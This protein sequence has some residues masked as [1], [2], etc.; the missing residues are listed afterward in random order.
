MAESRQ[1][2][3]AN[4][5]KAGAPPPGRAER[6]QYG[7]ERLANARQA[8]LAA[9]VMAGAMVLWVGVN[10]I[11]GRLGLPG[12]YALLADLAALAA[13]IWALAVTFRVWR[14]GR[15]LDREGL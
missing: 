3:R 15:E 1:V 5:R 12:R 14:K 13:F 9:I 8:R 11:G 10:L 4:A 6:R 2:R 7:P